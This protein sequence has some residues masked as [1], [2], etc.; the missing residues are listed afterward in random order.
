MTRARNWAM[1]SSVAPDV[2]SV[3]ASPWRVARVPVRSLV[4]LGEVALGDPRL[5]PAPLAVA[6]PVVRLTRLLARRIVFDVL[7]GLAQ[8]PFGLRILLLTAALPRLFAQTLA[9]QLRN[10]LDFRLTRP[11]EAFHLR[12]VLLERLFRH[13][14]GPTM[15]QTPFTQNSDTDYMQPDWNERSR[16]LLRLGRLQTGWAGMRSLVHP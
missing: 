16:R 1:P 2:P 6:G 7:G 14:C 4:P 11:R 15:G 10:I 12:L 3:E 13:A 8:S 5:V 9:H